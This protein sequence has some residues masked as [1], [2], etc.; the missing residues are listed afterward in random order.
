[1]RGRPRRRGSMTGRMV[2]G[3]TSGAQIVMEPNPY[4]AGPK[5]G[6]KRIILKHIENTAVLQ[7]N[8]LSGDVNMVAGEGVGLTIDQALELRKQQPDKFTYIFKPSLNY[9]HIDFKVGNPIL[10]DLRVRQAIVHAA[11]RK[12]MVEKLFQGMQPVADTWVNPLNPNFQSEI[13]HYP[14][15]PAKAK[16]L[17]AEAGWKPGADGICRNDKGERLSLE[18]TTTAGNRLR[19][20]QEQVL[21]SNWKAACI[22]ATIKNEPARTLFGETLKKRLYT[23]LAMYAWSSEVTRRSPRRTLAYRADPDRGQWLW[24]LE[25]HRLFQSADGQAD[26]PGRAG[27]RSREAEGDLGQYAGDLRQGSAG[28]AAL[29]PRRAAYRAEMAEGLHPDRP[30]RL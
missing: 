13:Q 22:E 25:L 15:D 28:D 23:G 10:A 2:T 1:M 26:R 11:D 4:W 3:Y 6:F 20:L 29:L 24:G 18:I 27:A 30:W 19:E 8:V 12:T 16:A 9:E 14:Y 17:L 7:A 5:P 21:Q